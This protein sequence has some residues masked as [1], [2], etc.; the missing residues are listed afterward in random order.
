[1]FYIHEKHLVVEISN[2]RLSNI[3]YIAEE[4]V[5]LVDQSV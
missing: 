3:G 4:V 2:L 5:S 1:M